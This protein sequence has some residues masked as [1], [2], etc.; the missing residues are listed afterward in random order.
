MK[1]HSLA[2]D[3]LWNVLSFAVR[4]VG[5]LLALAWVARALGPEGQGRFGFAAGLAALVATHNLALAAG[6]DRTMRLEGGCLIEA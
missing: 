2:S 3:T 5:T 1:P 4:T 6:L